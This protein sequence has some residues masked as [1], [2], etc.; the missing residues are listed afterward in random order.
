[1]KGRWN[2]DENRDD[3]NDP[4][5]LT[6]AKEQAAKRSVKELR[7][8][9]EVDPSE[10]PEVIAKRFDLTIIQDPNG[11]VLVHPIHDTSYKVLGVHRGEMSPLLNAVLMCAF[12]TRFG[13]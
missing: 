4:M 11:T 13:T 7:T 1:M 3:E 9:L 10:T 2:A 6:E 8:S 5:T 12:V